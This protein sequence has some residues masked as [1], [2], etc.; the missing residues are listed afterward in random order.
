MVEV[1]WNLTKK[2]LRRSRS[3]M[4]SQ[5]INSNLRYDNIGNFI[6][7]S[8]PQTRH[9]SKRCDS[10]TVYQCAKIA[11]KLNGLHS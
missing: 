9:R 2:M 5:S 10:R 8:D 11:A 7:K 4:D 1:I 3:L 6:V